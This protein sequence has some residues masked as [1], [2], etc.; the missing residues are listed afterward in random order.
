MDVVGGDSA[1]TADAPVIA[2][3][4]DDR[5]RHD[6]F[7]FAAVEDQGKTVAKLVEDFRAADAG[8]GVGNVGAGARQGDADFGNEVR[9]DLGFGP[10][11]RDAAG[12]GGDFQ[13]EAVGGINDDGERTRPAGVGEAIEIVGKF[14]GQDHGVIETADEDGEGAML[15]ASLHAKNFFDSGKIDGIGSESV[16]RVCRDGD[17]R[18]AVEPGGSIADDARVGIGC[19]DF[20]YL[21]RQAIPYLF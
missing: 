7:G 11:Q 15:G 9:D 21:G 10:A 6:G 17:D 18:A 2:F 13:R 3:E 5:R 4:F 1:E 16:K 14:A 8:R 19:A 20:E 12:V